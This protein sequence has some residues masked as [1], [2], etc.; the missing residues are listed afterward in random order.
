MGREAADRGD[1]KMANAA[2][3]E[4]RYSFLVFEPYRAVRKVAIFGSARTER[5]RPGLRGW[6]ATSAGAMAERDWM[7]IT[8]AGPGI[9]EAGIEGA[10][11]D[12]AFGVSIVLPV[13]AARP[14]PFLAGDP[15]LDQ[16]PLLLH[17]QAHVH[18]G[19]A[20]VRA[21]AR[22][23]R[24]ARRGVRAAHA[25]ADRQARRSCRS[26]CSTCPA[27]PTGSAGS[28][29]SRTELGGRR[30]H[31]RR[32]P[33]PRHAS[34]T[35]ST[36]PSTRSCSFYSNYHSHA[37]RRRPP[38]ACASQRD[39]SDER[40]RRAQHASSPTSSSRAPSSGCRPSRREVDDD[41]VPDLPRIAFRFDRTQLRPPA[42]PD[43]P[44]QRRSVIAAAIELDRVAHVEARAAEVQRAAR[45]GA[46]HDRRL[47]PIDRGQLALP[48]GPGQLRCSAA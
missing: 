34:P 8:G 20:R 38:R 3:K 35:T 9:M 47:R 21:A 31:L 46:G 7:V 18:E 13:R 17:P 2:L 19:V 1:L 48:D 11:A 23:L 24:H 22:R 27:A 42:P 41:D 40:A 45:V 12:H 33:R 25:G 6:P 36:R 10:G 29:S 28:S 4:L 30:P 5:R 43:R 39:V 15:K 44:A 16:L 37:L 14:R 26:C 32:R